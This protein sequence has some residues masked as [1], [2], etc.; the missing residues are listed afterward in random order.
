MAQISGKE[1]GLAVSKAS[2]LVH[3]ED[4]RTAGRATGAVAKGLKG[5]A[6]RLV[7]SALLVAIW[8]NVRSGTRRLHANSI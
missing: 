8:V 1:R 4:E 5:I 6:L 7:E 3:I 2:T